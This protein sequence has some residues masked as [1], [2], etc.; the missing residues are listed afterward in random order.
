MSGAWSRVVKGWL[1]GCV[2]ATI[3]AEVWLIAAAAWD[4][5]RANVA[6][7]ASDYLM[8]FGLTAP[9][10]LFAIAI[11]TAIP[12]AVIIG[13]TERFQIRSLLF[14]VCAG[15]AT[16]GLSQLMFDRTSSRLWMFVV[17][18]NAAGLGYWY[19]AGRHSG[20]GH[21]GRETD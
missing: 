9:F 10:I 19:V 21:P 6:F 7:A 3:A 20:R 14:Y 2:A 11:V 16:G 18:G 8:G 1:S 15:A 4:N 12:A 13:L 17:A 5:H